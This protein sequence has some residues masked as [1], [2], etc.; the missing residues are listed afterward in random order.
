MKRVLLIAA[1]AIG[2]LGCASQPM[3]EAYEAPGFF[4]GLWHGVVAPFALFAH[5]FDNSIR[6]YAFPNSGGW[7]DFG[8]I[9]GAGAWG[10]ARSM[11]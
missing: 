3:P 1:L 9:L 2:L 5:I 8:F 11:N 10:G 7:Y 4:W 6:I